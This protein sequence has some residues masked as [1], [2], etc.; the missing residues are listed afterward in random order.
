MDCSVAIAFAREGANISVVYQ[1][2]H[3]DAKETQ[4]LVEENGPQIYSDF[5]AMLVTKSFAVRRWKKSVRQ[6]RLTRIEVLRPTDNRMAR[7]KSHRP[8]VLS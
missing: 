7:R 3:K 4:R 1:E 2:E 6:T 5:V 8:M